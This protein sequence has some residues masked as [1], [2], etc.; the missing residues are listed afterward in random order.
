MS[1]VIAVS[2]NP[3]WSRNENCLNFF[4]NIFAAAQHKILHVVVPSASHPFFFA[5]DLA[6]GKAFWASA[7][8]GSNCLT[9]NTDVVV[10]PRVTKDYLY[11]P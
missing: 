10:A 5:A 4:E 6:T 8:S 3:Y 9:A 7:N 11:D 2:V 1:G